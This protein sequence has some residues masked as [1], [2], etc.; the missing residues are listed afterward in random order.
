V[1]YARKSLSILTVLMLSGVLMTT[2]LAAYP[3][4]DV[5]MS[6]VDGT[7]SYFVITL[8]GISA[9]E[10][11]S[12]G[13]YPGWCI[14]RNH[15][16]PRDE[17]LTVEL[18]SSL[19]PPTSLMGK[20]WDKVNYLLNNKDSYSMDD[21]QLA[22]WHFT[23][24]W[25][26]ENLPSSVQAIVDEADTNGNGYVPGPC[27]VLAIICV[28]EDT[29]AQTA[30]VELG[31]CPGFTPGFWKHNI[32]VALGYNPGK[33]SAFKDGPLDGVKVTEAKL[34]E[35][36]GIVGVSLEEAYNAVNAKG[37]PPNNMIRADMA[38]A[39][40]AAAGYGPFED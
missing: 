27:D 21:I 16:M 26:Y 1:K 18:Y 14:D 15:E 4:P 32:G 33:Y 17:D 36:A 31:Q 19:N 23:G 25:N 13:N 28:P 9:G 5:T 20:E 30:I 12:D 6:V 24:W 35:L 22:I 34:L 11:I 37:G 8:S 40:N 38:N 10:D 29:E 39:F 2:A 3:I 7:E